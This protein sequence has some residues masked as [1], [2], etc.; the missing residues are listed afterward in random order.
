MAII[1]DAT[2]SV[3]SSMADKPGQRRLFWIFFAAGL[4]IV[5]I[6]YYWLAGGKKSEQIPM[7]VETAAAP[8][9]SKAVPKEIKLEDIKLDTAFLKTEK[10]EALKVFGSFPIKIEAKGRLNPFA[11]F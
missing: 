10:F 8:G 7:G 11:T 5:L 9:L 1:P 2:K 4:A 3:S 6:L